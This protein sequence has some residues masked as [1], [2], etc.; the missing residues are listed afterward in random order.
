[1][2]KNYSFVKNT[3]ETLL[4]KLNDSINKYY[5]LIENLYSRFSFLEFLNIF[6][7]KR[8]K[9]VLMLNSEKIFQTCIHMNFEPP[10]FFF[11]INIYKYTYIS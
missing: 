4:M 5:S 2:R 9:T 7:P 6:G 11:P 1:M 8:I 10:N 3:R